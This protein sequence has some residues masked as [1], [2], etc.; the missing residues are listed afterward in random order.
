MVKPVRNG[1]VVCQPR[2]VR[3]EKKV[4]TNLF[5]NQFSPP[6]ANVGTIDLTK[7]NC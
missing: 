6:V 4:K 1:I 7:V 2:F 3:K 5:V